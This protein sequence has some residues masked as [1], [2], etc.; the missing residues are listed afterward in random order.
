MATLADLH[1]G[2][3][4]G[5]GKSKETHKQCKDCAFRDMTAVHGEE[6]GWYKCVC[7]LYPNPEMKPDYVRDNTADCE[8]YELNA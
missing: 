4:F 1:A 5:D 6:W 7:E 8:F 3:K 2:E